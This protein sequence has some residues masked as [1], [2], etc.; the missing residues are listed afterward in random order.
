MQHDSSGNGASISPIH[1]PTSFA[2]LAQQAPPDLHGMMRM[3]WLAARLNQL[4]A[5]DRRQARDDFDVLAERM[6]TLNA[7]DLDLGGPASEKNAWFRVDGRKTPHPDLGTFE[8]EA[9]DVWILCVLVGHQRKILLERFSVDFSYSLALNED[10]PDRRYRTTVYFDNQ[11][12]ALSM[13]LLAWKPRALRS[14]GFH[15]IIERGFLFRYVRDGLTLFT[16]VTGSG[17]STT[18]DAIVHAN[19]E[20]TEAHIL[21]VAQ[22]LEYIHTSNKCI[23]RHREVGTDVANF[24]D[25]MVQGLRQD[26]DIV[27]VGE[28]RDPE[29]IS[30]AMEMADTGHKVFSTLHTGSAIETIDRIVAE[31][32]SEEQDRVRHRLADVLRCVVS[33]KLLPS[34]GGGRT[35]AKEVLWMTPAARAAIKNGNTPEIY[36]MIWQ[37]QDQGMITLEQDLTR[38]V[39]QG[40]VTT[41][42]ALSYANNKRRLLQL[43]RS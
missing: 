42:T 11:H 3:R 2:A 14:L 18:L 1:I 22:P 27:I 43:M 36:Q 19:N 29:T 38:L 23:I 12:L 25:G 39:R 40:E 17:K 5:A 6:V 34:V 30:T 37:G 21:I 26:P 35:L 15:P 8:I 16:G 24:V 13:R 10:E 28:M 7:S 31:Y 20:D 4:P 32:P 33:Q 9:T 41:E